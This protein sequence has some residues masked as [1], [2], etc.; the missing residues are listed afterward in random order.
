[1]KILYV[2][3]IIS[4]IGLIP[5]PNIETEQLL[6]GHCIVLTGYDN[7]NETFTFINDFGSSFGNNGRGLIPYE[8]IL[9]DNLTFNLFTINTVTNPRTL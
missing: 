5:M 2:E 8:Y 3:E 6:G 1:M 9:N 4:D 7:T